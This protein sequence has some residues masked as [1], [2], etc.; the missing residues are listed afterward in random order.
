MIS[1]VTRQKLL[2]NILPKQLLGIDRA[3][4]HA[5]HQQSKAAGNSSDTVN[6]I[7]PASYL[8]TTDVCRSKNA[9]RS[10]KG[11]IIVEAV[12]AQCALALFR[13]Y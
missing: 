5:A 2:Y 6:H 12:Q 11:G 3:A 7:M 13:I 4:A 10:S 1:L 8:L 9:M